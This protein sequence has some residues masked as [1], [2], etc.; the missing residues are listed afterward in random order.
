MIQEKYSFFQCFSFSKE[1]K[2][3]EEKKTY[4]HIQV[5]DIRITLDV[6]TSSMCVD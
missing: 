3:E 2:E 4:R 1:N 6:I 5:T